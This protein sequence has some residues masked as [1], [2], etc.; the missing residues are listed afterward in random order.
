MR[1][2]RPGR[3]L[4]LTQCTWGVKK[5]EDNEVL[6]L[7]ERA[8]AEGDRAERTK[9]LYLATARD[10]LGWWRRERAERDV[11]SAETADI[12]AYID[13]VERAH[14]KPGLRAAAST[15][16]IYLRGVKALYDAL[17]DAG[18]IARNPAA[19][20]RGVRQGPPRP[21]WLSE[22]EQER[23]QS[24]LAR[25]K[26]FPRVIALLM[27]QAGLRRQEVLSLTWGDITPSDI[28]VLGKGRRERK[29]PL[30]RPLA[31]ALAAWKLEAT[32][33]GLPAGPGDRVVPVSR[34][35]LT[36]H[37]HQLAKQAGIKR[38]APHQL[39][40][41]FIHNLTVSGV[42]L[43]VAASLAGHGNVNT[44]R[45]YTEPSEAELAAAMEAAGLRDRPQQQG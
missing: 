44:T 6:A 5:V 4:P 30:T 29:V 42:R 31:Q 26:P 38:F 23:L 16:N 11:L 25:A 22:Q 15:I 3:A 33:R 28:R 9:Q 27:L 43:E 8:V 40:H 1:G 17:L 19:R 2:E 39:R 45:R 41:T 35:T 36:H 24:A 21:R 12:R 18:L 32:H 37:V 7:L 20:V 10:F 34:E 14:A 13:H